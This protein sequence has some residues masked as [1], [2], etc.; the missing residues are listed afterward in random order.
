[1]IQLHTLRPMGYF[2]MGGWRAS[3]QCTQRLFFFVN[4]IKQN[5]SYF[6]VCKWWLGDF[7]FSPIFMNRN[8]IA[9]SLFLFILLWLN[10]T[11]FLWPIDTKAINFM[12]QTPFFLSVAFYMRDQIL[13]CLRVKVCSEPWID[14]L[15]SLTR[16]SN[17]CL[18]VENEKYAIIV[19][20]F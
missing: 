15:S 1:M 3:P 10:E 9:R 6:R 2:L 12:W 4:K 5:K 11:T 17:V 14:F 7:S 20:R 18:F 8:R 16:K 19:F 13:F